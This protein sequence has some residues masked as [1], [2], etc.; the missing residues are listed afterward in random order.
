[1]VAVADAGLSNRWALFN[2]AP[3][4]V[5]KRFDDM[6]ATGIL[7]FN[8][9]FASIQALQNIG[10]ALGLIN[11]TITI[12]TEVINEPSIADLEP[13]VIDISQFRVDFPTQPTAPSLIDATLEPIPSAFP[14]ME[15]PGNVNAGDLTYVSN[16]MTALKAKI[17]SDIQNGSTGIPDD[18]QDAMFSRNRERDLLELD[19]ELDRV[20]ANWG[21]GGFPFPNGGLRAAQRKTTREFSNKRTDVSREIMIKSWEIA[22]QNTHFMIQQGIAVEGLLIQFA[23]QVATRVFEASKAV[24]DTEIRAYEARVKGFGEK[25]R[26]IIEKCKAKIEFNLG[27]IRMYEASVN[28]YASK[29]R[30]EAERINAVARGY[31]AETAVFTS[32]ADF[33]IKKVDLDLKV[34]QARIDQALG[35]AQI[36]IKDKE[37]ELKA[38]EMLNGLKGEIAKAIGMIAA[39]VASGALS[40]VHAQ[41]HIG[42]QD[43]ADYSAKNGELLLA[44]LLP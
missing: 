16:L 34:I 11:R 43:S 39:Q 1:M 14:D 35:N 32:T 25:A 42:A 18:I 38:Y 36:M 33:D 27:L 22:L 40:A 19:D 15:G 30:A 29:M 26:I 21:K 31:E 6:Q 37:V 8:M 13:P 9:A 10:Q 23:N 2:D 24:I 20:A 44:G 4:L 17:L 3:T 5:K 12:D 28:A 7:G 41:V